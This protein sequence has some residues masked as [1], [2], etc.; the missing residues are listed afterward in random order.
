[1]TLR[2]ATRQ[3]PLAL[4]QA[5][6]V[7]DQLL[8]HWP[9]LSIEL[10]PMVTSGDRFL[11]DALLTVGGKGLF[12][13]ELEEALLD[14]RADL[15]VHSVKDLPASF[16]KGLTLAAIGQ[17]HS[18]WDALLSQNFASLNDLPLGAKVGTAS[19][20]RQSQLLTLRPDLRLSTLRGNVQTRIKALDQGQF[21]A[22]VLAAAGLER[23]GLE[24][25]IRQRFDAAEMLPA[26][27]QGAL[28]IE[29]RSNDKHTRKLV[30]ALNHPLTALCV[31]TERRV[32]QRLGGNCRLPLAVFC[33]PE[34]GSMLRLT[35]KVASANGSLVILDEQCGTQED[36]S[37]LADRCAEALLSQGAAEILAC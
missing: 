6:H 21:D 33:C 13:K 36:A 32:N 28:G 25:R 26:C 17:R 34:S 30:A 4:W 16:P 5:E 27:G 22:I 20:R 29:C 15:A 11:S 8:H 35:A 3:S 31:A 37:L 9:D 1:M 10:L 19:L 2:I 23:L 24:H 18:P 14:Q 7:R 12:V